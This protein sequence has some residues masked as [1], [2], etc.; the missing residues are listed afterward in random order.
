MADAGAAPTS[1]LFGGGGQHV[2]TLQD[3]GRLQMAHP[4]HAD[5]GPAHATSDGRGG[6]SY[7]DA[8][9]PPSLSTQ[10]THLSADDAYPV[11]VS[12]GGLDVITSDG[13]HEDG[14]TS[15]RIASVSLI[16]TGEAIAARMARTKVGLLRFSMSFYD[17]LWEYGI[18]VYSLLSG[19]EMEL[20][21][22]SIDSCHIMKGCT[23]GH[24][25]NSKYSRILADT[26]THVLS[27]REPTIGCQRLRI[28]AAAD[29][30]GPLAY[31]LSVEADLDE[32]CPPLTTGNRG[33][34]EMPEG[35]EGRPHPDK[36]DEPGKRCRLALPPMPLQ[37]PPV[38]ALGEPTPPQP[39]HNRKSCRLMTPRLPIS[40]AQISFVR[41]CARRQARPRPIAPCAVLPAQ[42]CSRGRGPAAAR[43]LKAGARCQCALCLW[44]RCQW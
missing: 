18:S 41:T 22:S 35:A 11:G 9:V 33:L 38:T 31:L 3:Y 40:C 1:L 21:L 43:W 44:P 4:N 34:S 26:S 39:H 24:H 37:L 7:D 27:G 5:V 10:P 14:F 20:Y 30:D 36:P 16:Y 32:A 23:S 6:L 29:P 15:E 8:R 12:A 25:P 2:P 13:G 17:S 19:R 42:V 28:A